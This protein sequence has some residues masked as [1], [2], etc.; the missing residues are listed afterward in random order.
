MK[1]NLYELIMSDEVLRKKVLIEFGFGKVSPA[2][3]E[4]WVRQHYPMTFNNLLKQAARRK[5]LQFEAE[6]M[7]ADERTKILDSIFG[8]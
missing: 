7:T 4:K 5:V 2:K 3:V 1:M 8:K 6:T